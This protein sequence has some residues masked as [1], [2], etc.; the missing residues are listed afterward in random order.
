MSD[1]PTRGERNHNPGNIDW[2]PKVAWLGQVPD[3]ERNDDRFCEFDDDLHGIR[4]LCRILVNYQRLDGCRTLG[5]MIRRWAPP[6]ENNTE[7]YIKD[8]AGRSGI[9]ADGPVDVERPGELI[10]IAKGIICHENGSCNYAS[11]LF[12]QAAGMA[13]SK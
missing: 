5:D 2:N 7:A 10:A 4:A 1:Q 9:T 8:V 3:W 13:L 6:E 11:D 12:A